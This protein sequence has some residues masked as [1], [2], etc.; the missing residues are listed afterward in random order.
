MSARCCA[1]LSAPRLPR[2]VSAKVSSSAFRKL[3]SDVHAGCVFQARGCETVTAFYVMILDF[4]RLS[5]L[6]IVHVSEF[7]S[8]QTLCHAF[9]TS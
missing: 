9:S 6:V 1:A 8:P 4:I 5:S 2:L 3:V 7:I